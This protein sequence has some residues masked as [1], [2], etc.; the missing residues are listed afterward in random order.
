MRT[1]NTWNQVVRETTTLIYL[2]LDTGCEACNNIV[3]FARTLF[4]LL[5]CKCLAHLSEH[6]CTVV[7][8]V[9][10]N[11]STLVKLTATY[12]YR[13][14]SPLHGT[15]G[16]TFPPKGWYSLAIQ[17]PNAILMQPSMSTLN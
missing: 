15:N 13:C 17:L 4:L 5:P 16:F 10:S 14:E 3:S 12:M 11:H 7:F 6:Q 2:N 1:T 8:E 9:K